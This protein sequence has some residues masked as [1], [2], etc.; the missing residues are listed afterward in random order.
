MIKRLRKQDVLLAGIIILF[1]IPSIAPLLNKGFFVT[2]DG[3]WMI[4]RLSAFY[5]AFADGQ[6]PV[7]FL[8]RLNFDYGYPVA[9]FVYPGFMYIGS[10]IHLLK[11]SFVD[12]IKVILGL[13][14]AGS[15]VF[16][17]FWL[18]NFFSKSAS[19][20]GGLFYLYSPYYLYDVYERGSV[21]EVLAL[22]ILPFVLWQLERKSILWASISIGIL[23]TAHNTLALLF[24][25]FIFLYVFLNYSVSKNRKQFYN[26]VLSVTLGFGISAFFWLP[27]I[28]ELEN[29]IFSKTIVSDWREYFASI[30][31]AGYSTILVF[32]TSLLLLLSKKAEINKHRLAVLFLGVGIFSTFMATKF[33][34]FLWQF[35]PV[36]FIQFPFRFLSVTLISAAF[37]SAFAFSMFRNINKLVFMIVSIAILTFSA[38][39]YLTNVDYVDKG[40]GYYVTNDS[41]TTVKNEYTPTWVKEIPTQRPSKKV[42]VVKGNGEIQNLVHA[43]NKISFVADI[44]YSEAIVK[45]NT[46]YWPGWKLYK[47]NEEI[48]VTYN[49]PQGVTTFI[50]DPGI[51]QLELRFEET[52]NRLVSDIISV[53]SLVVLLAFS[54]KNRSA[55]NKIGNKRYE[56]SK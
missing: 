56:N 14:M 12:T 53:T 19:V 39:Q 33:S 21:G 22:G 23:I 24:I 16:T 10:F 25:T 34:I 28:T 4:I 55:K 35:F 48:K 26:N 17:F 9:T 31:L 47:N 36:G 32:I 37:L 43:S 52:K 18:K 45:I 51:W 6:F 11:I 46:I 8:H 50:L 54:V 41:T 15:M 27:A 30:S 20:I 49:N 1:L 42:E 13:S 29:T 5:Q 38:F 2:D 44:K 40:E 3:E 7:R